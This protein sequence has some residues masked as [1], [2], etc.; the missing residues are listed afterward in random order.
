M[1]RF[2]WLA[3]LFA[4]V[5]AGAEGALFGVVGAQPTWESG[6]TPV[7]FLIEGALFGLSLVV[8]AGALFKLLAAETA[9][10]LGQAL[11]ALL[12]ALV[13]VEAFE[14]FT[15]LRAAVPAK[16]HAFEAILTGEYWWVFWVFHL[17]LGIVVPAAVLFRAKGRIALVGGAGALIAS[18][19]LASKLNLVVPALA[20]HEDIEGLSAAFTGPGLVHE[21]VPSAMEWLVTIGTIGLAALV[22]L[23]GHRL[24]HHVGGDGEPTA[25]P[26]K[27]QKGVKVWTRT[28][29]STKTET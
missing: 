16:E 22:V 10:R 17:G 26:K 25:P 23:A 6:L 4:I 5:F 12:V 20:A 8:A 1:E 29:V 14:F 21:Y 2:A 7:V 28:V 18:M 27:I 24:L 9:R 13:V 11:L 3:F 15:G 19:A